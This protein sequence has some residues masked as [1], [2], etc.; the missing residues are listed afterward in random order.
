M[1]PSQRFRTWSKSRASRLPKASYLLGHPVHLTLATA[2]R[3]PVLLNPLLARQV[4]DLAAREPD[5][6]AACLMPDHFHWLVVPSESPGILVRRFKLS[7][8]KVAWG[9]GMKG[10]LWQRSFY[11]HVVR[12]EEDLARTLRYIVENPVEEGLVDCAEKW[13]YQFWRGRAAGT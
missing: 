3:A 2:R 8:L 6:M 5:T 10:T 11:D 1:K 12:D 4:V 13:P 9:L 7:S